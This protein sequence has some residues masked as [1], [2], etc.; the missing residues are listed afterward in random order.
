MKKKILIGLLL[1]LIGIQFIRPQQNT[2]PADT[3]SDITHYMQVPE[4]VLHTLKVSCYDCHSNHTSYPWYA[5]IN[6][7]GLWLTYHVNEGKSELNFSDVATYDKKKLDH[8][9]EEIA[10]QVNEKEMPLSSY[11]L[12]HKDAVLS[13]EQIKQIV[14]WVKTERQRLVVSN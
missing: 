11:T 6:P 13:D 3:P 14:D 12:I 4:N 8:K 9:L 7:V 10:E 1:L 2:G 5:Q